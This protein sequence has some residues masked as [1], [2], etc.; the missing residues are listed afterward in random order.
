[1]NLNKIIIAISFTSIFLSLPIP[2]YAVNT[3]NFGSCV[4]PQGK[5]IASYKSGKHG[6]V[7]MNS[8]VSGSDSVY[9]SSNTGVTQ[10]FCPEDGKGI[11]TN[12]YDVSNVPQKDIDILKKEGWTF[13]ATGSKWGLKDV[14]YVAKNADYACNK[15]A[16]KKSKTT[17]VLK[18]ASTGETQ[19]I[20][21]FLLSGA[22]FLIAGLILRKFSK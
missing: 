12:W 4:N 2:V 8:E 7:G 20:Y 15:T 6:I 10:C 13:F 19:T 18:L 14:P 5:V 1:M 17:E 11:Q 22:A 3:P 9:Q 16:V 21:T